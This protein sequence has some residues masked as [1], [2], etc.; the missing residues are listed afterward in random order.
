MK[1][2][3]GQHYQH[4]KGDILVVRRIGDKGVIHLEDLSGAP[5]QTTTK[6]LAKHYKKTDAPKRRQ[7]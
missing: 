7:P 6:A 1:I 5:R 4:E 2:E 3:V